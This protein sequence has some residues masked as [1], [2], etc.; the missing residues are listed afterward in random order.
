MEDIVGYKIKNK[1][2]F[3]Q[4]FRHKSVITDETDLKSYERLE[5]LGDSILNVIITTHLYEKY[6]HENEGFLTRIR[7]KIVSGK[8]LSQI[9]SDLKLFNF[10]Q[11]NDKAIEKQWN[12]NA[13]MLEDVLESLIGAIYLDSGMKQASD[14]VHNKII[15]TFDDDLL[16]EDTNYKDILMRYLQGRKLNLPEYKFVD[17]VKVDDIKKFRI[18]IYIN[19]KFVSEG[20]HKVKKQSEQIAAKRALQCF[21]IV[22]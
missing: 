13:N 21:N 4:A 18:N 20:I 3:D 9:A 1:D 5:F 17:E 15:N 22:K 6:P 8:A 19:N 7:T 12:K 16:L 14:F 10:I 11:M 2:I